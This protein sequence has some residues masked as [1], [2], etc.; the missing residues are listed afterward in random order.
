M[1]KVMLFTIANH[2]RPFFQIQNTKYCQSILGEILACCVIL[3]FVQCAHFITCNELFTI[4]KL[5]VSLIL[6]EFVA[7]FISTH[8]DLIIWP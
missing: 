7:T 8:N 2:L 6:H 5:T 3:K 4:G 1:N